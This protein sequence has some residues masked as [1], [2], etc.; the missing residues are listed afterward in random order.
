MAFCTSIVDELRC[1]PCV[2]GPGRAI[3]SGNSNSNYVRTLFYTGFVNF[4]FYKFTHIFHFSLSFF[5]SP[6]KM[7]TP[8]KY[9]YCTHSVVSLCQC[10][11]RRIQHCP[12]L[13][14]A[15]WRMDVG[16]G[17]SHGSWIMDHGLRLVGDAVRACV[18][19]LHALEVV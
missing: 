16:A 14:L 1:W 12:S 6:R 2:H 8:T 17:L 15:G 19:V 9:I 4:L 18:G 3:P 10:P 7:D 11:S 13:G 5:S